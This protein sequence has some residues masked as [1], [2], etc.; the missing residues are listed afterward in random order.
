MKISAS[1]GARSAALLVALAGAMLAAAPRVA[2]SQDVVRT[3]Q[4]Y[5]AVPPMPSPS[6]AAAAP[7]PAPIAAKP[8]PFASL[9]AS[10]LAMRDSVVARARAQLGKRYRHGGETPKHG[11]DCSGLVAYVLSSFN[12]AVPRTAAAQATVGA[13]VVRDTSQLLPGDLL[14][15]GSKKVTHIGIYI[16][17][18]RFIQASSRAGKVVETNLFRAP[19]PGIRPWRGARRVAMATAPENRQPAG[20]RVPPTDLIE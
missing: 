2:S 4:S 8:A 20:G 5:L 15:F 17:N 9:S 1:S 6:V 3:S 18:G 11:F 19:A 12:F 14:T 10:M 16:G 13:E 7:I